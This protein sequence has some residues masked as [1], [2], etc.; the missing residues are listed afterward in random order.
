MVQIPSVCE[1][2]SADVVDEDDWAFLPAFQ[3]EPKKKGLT[4]RTEFVYSM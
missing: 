4:Y 2:G 1:A 3:K